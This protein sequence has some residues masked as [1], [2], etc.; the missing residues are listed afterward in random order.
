VIAPDF[1]RLLLAAALA[2]SGAPASA[3]TTQEPPPPDAS[4]AVEEIRAIQLTEVPNY[5]ETT[6]AELRDL[7]P[8]EQFAERIREITAELAAMSAEINAQ[9]ERARHGLNTAPR[10]RHLEEL[11]ADLKGLL[12]PLERWNRELAETSSV[13]ADALQRVER[14]EVI[15]EATEAV[16]RE[17]QSDAA[18]RWITQTRADLSATRRELV[19]LRDSILSLRDQLVSRKDNVQRVALLVDAVLDERLE[20]VLALDQPALWSGGY[21]RQLRAEGLRG[22]GARAAKRLQS[23]GD[24]VRAH[25]REVGFQVALFLAL[26][27]LLRIVSTRARLRAEESYDLREAEVAF[28]FPFSMAFVVAVA[29]SPWLHPVAP[30]LYR[31]VTGTIALAGAVLIVRRLTPPIM[32]PLVV[33]L[34]VFLLIDG[35][36]VLLDASQAVERFVFVAELCAA[37]AFI[38]WL[39]R[40]SR[41]AEI[42]Q[43]LLELRYLRIVGFALRA[44]FVL[45]G[46]ALVSEIAGLSDLANLVGDGTLR[47]AYAGLIAFALLKVLQ[48]M[49]AYA[50]ALPPLHSLR[51]VA[52]HRSFVRRRLDTLLLFAVSTLWVWRA[53]AFFGVANDVYDFGDA[54]LG[55]NLT[56]GAVSI[57][58]GDVAVFAVTVWGSLWL[59]R[60]V[61]FVLEE[62]VFPRMSV[63]R[64]V[65]YA[66]SN[67]VRYTL[68]F[69]GFLVALAAAG[70]EL[71]KLTV[72]IGG[73]GVGIGFG[74]QNVVNNF[75]SGLI[76]LFER[77]LQVGDVIQL[78]DLWGEIRHIG[79][80]ASVV[81]SW[82]GAEVIVPN[83]RLVSETMTNWTLSDRRRR[84]ELNVGVEYGTPVARVIELLVRVASA[85][86][87]VLDTPPPRA[88]FLNFGESSLD[89][90]LWAWIGDF[91]QSFQVTSDLHAAIQQ[92]L[93][94][95]GISVPFPQRDLHV[96]SLDSNAAAGLARGATPG[97]GGRN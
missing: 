67:L 24:Y 59:A 93:A 73:L 66:I 95:A 16:A 21:W 29:A 18:L 9:L 88:F 7:V 12:R 51:L 63:A 64:G 97:E 19:R 3:A 41:I 2:I 89:F 71:G 78:P 10:I 43:E 42:T 72:I 36:R 69:L 86:P 8:R 1:R 75:V 74:L 65:P 62:D 87:D 53:L 25:R 4:E 30:A 81:R 49:V 40:P 44:A 84:L 70:I 22:A 20:S 45:L 48:S 61:N 27:A 82:N 47:S 6:A 33:S 14:G 77:P 76:L 28:Q 54:V 58:L 60:L 90:R 79:I 31:V 55:A 46:V 91:D 92:A 37:L 32:G 94:D 11:R 85:H 50:L 5:A 57:S 17:E 13:V 52:R 39:Q 23:V 56:I 26:A 83:G 68:I 15:W 80:R 34:P 38:W 35:L 96:R